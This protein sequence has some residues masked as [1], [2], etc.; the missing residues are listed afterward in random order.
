MSFAEF[1]SHIESELRIV[2][3]LRVSFRGNELQIPTGRE[4]SSTAVRVLRLAAASSDRYFI[5]PITGAGGTHIQDPGRRGIKLGT[6]PFPRQT[7]V[8][9][10]RGITI[11]HEFA[12]VFSQQLAGP[13]HAQ[14]LRQLQQRYQSALSGGRLTGTFTTEEL[15]QIT[16]SYIGQG[17]NQEVIPVEIANRVRSELGLGIRRVTYRTPVMIQG[18]VVEYSQ[19]QVQ[20]SPLFIYQRLTDGALFASSVDFMQL[21]TRQGLP[22]T[23]GRNQLRPISAFPSLSRFL[24]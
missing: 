13:G 6:G 23:P 2:T 5:D 7:L 17:T 12:H 24:L 18:R 1:K 8:G 3:G 16:E 14:R 10:R 15:G 4:A 11:I 9:M 20:G 22:A 19:F 21:G